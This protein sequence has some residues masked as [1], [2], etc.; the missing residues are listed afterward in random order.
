MDPSHFTQ[1]DVMTP[2]GAATLELFACHGMEFSKAADKLRDMFENDR[3][4]PA[5]INFPPES[6]RVYYACRGLGINVVPMPV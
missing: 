4:C 5:S 6:V 1:A 3:A 2:L